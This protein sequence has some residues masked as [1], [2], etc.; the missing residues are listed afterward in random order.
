[1]S[2]KIPPFAI[3]SELPGEAKAGAYEVRTENDAPTDPGYAIFPILRQDTLGKLHLIGTGFFITTNGLFVTANHVLMEVF[4]PKGQQK[5]PIIIAQ[6]L[7]NN[8]YLQRPILR[9]VS[10]RIADIAVGVAAPMKNNKDGQPLTNPIVALTLRVPA[11]N[12]SIFTYAYPKHKN[13]VLD[14]GPQILNFVPTFYDGNVLESFPDGRDRVLLPGPCYRTSM[15][16]HG[17]ASGGPVFCKNGCVFAVNSTGIDGT[18]ISFVS[19]LNEIFTLAIDGVSLDG[20]PPQS[21]TLIE[22]AGKGHIVVKA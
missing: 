16:I 11:L 4:G 14:G 12:E 8:T 1:M 3:P 7:P 2:D 18:D 20:G 9:S 17:G 10:H 22:I 5:D 21:T 6:F 15:T 19:R 13:I